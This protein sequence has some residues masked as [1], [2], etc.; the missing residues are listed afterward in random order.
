MLFFWKFSKKFVI[1][2]L[3]K[4]YGIHVDIVHMR[5]GDSRISSV[6]SLF[7]ESIWHLPHT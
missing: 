4:P 3:A 2:Q 1:T 7:V 6:S 5:L